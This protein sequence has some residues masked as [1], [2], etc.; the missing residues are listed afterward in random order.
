MT[1]LLK[2]IFFALALAVILWLGYKLFF[3]EDDASRT[4]L[5]AEVA[6]QAARD[7][8]EFL[9]TLQQLRDIELSQQIF[10]DARF[11]SF[12]DHRQAVVPEPVGRLN[13]FAPIGR[14]E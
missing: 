2:N 10:T 7:T 12:V 1:S 14:Q 11:Q 6:S 5:N 4:A 9:Q 3:A 13:P 8:Q